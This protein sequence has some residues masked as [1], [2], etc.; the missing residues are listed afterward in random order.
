[1]RRWIIVSSELG[2]GPAFQ[3][4]LP[5]LKT[6]L[7]KIT[8]WSSFTKVQ[9]GGET[10]LLVEDDTLLRTSTRTALQRLGYR[11]LEATN[12]P[13]AVAT[14]ELH[15]AEIALLLTDLM[16]PGGMSGKALGEQI[17]K[18][19]PKL[20]V[21]YVSGYSADIAGGDFQVEEGVNF[22]TKPFEIA[23]LAQIVRK[24]LE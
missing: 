7:P 6:P 2:Q 12:S 14:W 24:C 15:Q 17:L 23:K 22:L 20:K 5:S 10:I 8:E 19:N 4:Y 11:V 18:C 9:G 16:M 13:D 1:M 21:I 3:V